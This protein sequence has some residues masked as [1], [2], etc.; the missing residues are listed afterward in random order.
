MCVCETGVRVCVCVL[1]IQV[2]SNRKTAISVRRV[3][4][5]DTIRRYDRV[6]SLSTRNNAESSAQERSEAAADKADKADSADKTREKPQQQQQQQQVIINFK[7]K[8]KNKTKR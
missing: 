1:M 8:I 6:S 3:V 4:A 7:T 2:K 5:Y